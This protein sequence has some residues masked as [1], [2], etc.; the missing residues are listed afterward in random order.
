MSCG[1][2]NNMSNKYGGNMYGKK[3][4]AKKQSSGQKAYATVKP[5]KGGM[6]KPSVSF[7]GYSYKEY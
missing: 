1:C 3:K 5:K 6:R 4:S 2:K 7:K